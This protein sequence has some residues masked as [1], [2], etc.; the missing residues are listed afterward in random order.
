[1]AVPGHDVGVTV[2]V[3]FSAV[4][5]LL[6]VAV[7]LGLLIWAAKCDGRVQRE[8]DRGAGL[9]G[10][11]RRWPP[12]RVAYIA[13]GAGRAAQPPHPGFHSFEGLTSTPGR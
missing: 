1:M 8:H 2:V 9:Q 3:L 13:R 6:G 12:T 4:V 11:W 7:W 10:I 5:C